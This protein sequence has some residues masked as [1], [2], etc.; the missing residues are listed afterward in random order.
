[1]KFYLA[2]GNNINEYNKI[3]KIIIIF[4]DIKNIG[5]P[6]QNEILINEDTYI[7]LEKMKR[8]MEKK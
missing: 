6:I 2:E 3:L 4:Y 8:E 1:M 5:E 7:Q